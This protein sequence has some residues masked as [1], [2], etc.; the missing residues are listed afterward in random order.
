MIKVD[1]LIQD[2]TMGGYVDAIGD[3]FNAK[4][5]NNIQL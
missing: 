4:Q 3:Q 5:T 2:A 1:I